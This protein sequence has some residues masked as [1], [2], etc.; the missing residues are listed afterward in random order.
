MVG[1]SYVVT[2]LI[3]AGAL[4]HNGKKCTVIEVISAEQK[5]KVKVGSGETFLVK[6]DKL[7]YK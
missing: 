2:G 7:R 4:Q 3:S 1:A 5:A 6:Y